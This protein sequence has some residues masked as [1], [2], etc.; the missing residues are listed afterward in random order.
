[1]DNKKDSTVSGYERGRQNKQQRSGIFELYETD[2]P[3]V[4]K[5]EQLATAV[6]LVTDF[7]PEHDRLRVQLRLRCLE[8]LSDI[9]RKKSG[10]QLI[11]Q[12]GELVALV[13]IAKIARLVSEMNAEILVSEYEKLKELLHNRI[14]RAHLDALPGTLFGEGK[15]VDEHD[16]I[17]DISLGHARRAGFKGHGGGNAFADKELSFSSGGGVS[18]TLSPSESAKQRKNTIL[19]LLKKMT[20]ITVKDVSAVITDCSEKTLQRELIGLVQ[21]GVLK[22]EGERRWSHYSL[23]V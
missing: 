19:S 8:L 15:G 23:R 16:Y 10:A 2:A 17:K 13:T 7:V 1:M 6:Y 22:K 4:R 11:R 14:A 3:I 20:A 5:A 9:V 21:D 18:K 12:T